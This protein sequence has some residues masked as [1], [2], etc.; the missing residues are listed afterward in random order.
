[1]AIPYH[2]TQRSRLHHL[3]LH[4]TGL[5]Q[6]DNQPLQRCYYI[7]SGS[8]GHHHCCFLSH[9]PMSENGLGL[10]FL[11][12]VPYVQHNK[13]YLLTCLVRPL[14]PLQTAIFPTGSLAGC[15]GNLHA[16]CIRMGLENGLGID[17]PGQQKLPSQKI[18]HFFTQKKLLHRDRNKLSPSTQLDDHSLPRYCLPLRRPQPRHLR[19]RISRNHPQGHLEPFPSLERALSKL[20]LIPSDP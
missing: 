16:L 15:F 5:R 4:Q 1:V 14:L 2:P 20:R 13:V 10:R 8:S 3:L 12:P 11:L 9:S 6:T 19:H 7:L 18:P 17:E